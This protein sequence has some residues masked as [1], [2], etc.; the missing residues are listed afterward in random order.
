MIRPRVLLADDHTGN[1]RLLRNLLEMEFDVVGAV[2]N[3]YA[4]VSAAETLLPDVIVCDISMP[5]LDGIE[6]ARRI[7]GRNAAARI[8]FVSVHG[9]PEVV[10]RS[11]AIGGLGYVLKIVAG[12]ELVPAVRAA[13]RGERHVGVPYRAAGGQPEGL[14]DRSTN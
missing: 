4:L 14:G 9:E 12:E 2:E 8:V 11:L 3:G 5:G 10:K 13:L 6:A 7:L 1:T